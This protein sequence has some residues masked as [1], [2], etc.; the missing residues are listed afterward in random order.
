V[1]VN[2][3]SDVLI[4][5]GRIYNCTIDDIRRAGGTDLVVNLI[6]TATGLTISRWRVA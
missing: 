1:S 5:E 4:N 2:A 6:A 3:G